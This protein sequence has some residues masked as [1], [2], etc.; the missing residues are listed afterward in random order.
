MKAAVLYGKEDLRFEDVPMPQTGRGEVLVQVRATGIC[1]SDIPRVLGEGAHHYPVILGHEFCGTVA[2][3][4]EGVTRV[5]PGDRVAGVPLLPCMICED[6]L[7]GDYALCRHYSFIGSRVQGGFA[8]Y[9][10]LPEKNVVKFDDSIPFTQGAFF[11][12]ASVAFHGLMRVDYQGGGDVAVLGAGTIGIFT[13]QWARIFGARRV[14][15]FDIDPDRL[16]LAEKYGADFTVNS[17]EEG[18]Q[19]KVQQITGG[20]GFQYVYE[21]AG[22][23]AAMKSVFEI[24]GSKARV[25]LVGTPVREITCTPRLLENIHR[26]EFLL[27]GSWMS[28]SAPF[29]GREWHLTAHYFNTGQLKFDES[30]IYLKLPLERIGEGFAQYRTPGQVKGKILVIQEA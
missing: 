24:A 25:C 8:E 23:E 15:V 3:T 20:K 30:L 19:E 29:P 6:C 22:A 18:F 9:V 26:K 17:L 16:K 1:G 5:K 7:R 27:T 12:P 21:T 4:G 2:E 28:Y 10:C 13:L 11:E 14:A